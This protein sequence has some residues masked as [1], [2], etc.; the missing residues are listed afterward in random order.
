MP[1]NPPP[2]T[3]SEVVHRAVEACDDGS[4]TEALDELLERFEDDDEPIAAVEDIEITLDET[5]GPRDPDDDP[6]AFVMACAVIVYLAHRRDE[7]EADAIELL[8]LA[9]RAEFDGHPPPAVASWLGQ[10]GVSL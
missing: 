8:R 6:P 9:A 3:V 10:R 4:G 1:T 2:V 5:V 7:L